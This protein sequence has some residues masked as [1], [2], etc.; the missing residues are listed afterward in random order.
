MANEPALRFAPNGWSVEF[1][2][3]LG[4]D[5]TR[6]GIIDPLWGRDDPSPWAIQSSAT[7][8]KTVL[9]VGLSLSSLPKPAA[10]ACQRLG[11][12]LARLGHN[13]VVGCLPGVDEAVTVAF[14]EARADLSRLMQVVK[15]GGHPFFEEGKRVSARNSEDSL[16]LRLADVDAVVLINGVEGT[17][18]AAE[19]AE[20]AGLPVFPI[21]QT[22]G[23]ALE[24]YLRL[25]ERRPFGRA[26]TPTERFA[27]LNEEVPA[28]IDL[29]FH[30]LQHWK[31][32]A[33]PPSAAVS[34]SGTTSAAGRSKTRPAKPTR[35]LPARK[36]K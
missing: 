30:V 34:E 10:E 27:L 4:H 13:L 15:K 29:L 28:A 1:D 5:L 2:R 36:K 32:S 6:S 3:M 9:V 33:A 20:A 25:A 23:A 35:K 14:I 24:Y 21:A 7:P 31:W 19:A 8:A 17:M 26:G 12:S 11:H 22:G 18:R 16:K